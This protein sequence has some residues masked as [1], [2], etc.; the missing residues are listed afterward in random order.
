MM[1][2]F[3]ADQAEPHDLDKPIFDAA[4]LKQHGRRAASSSPPG[5][6]V[7]VAVISPPSSTITSSKERRCMCRSN[8]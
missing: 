7:R 6:M 1:S 8:R 5:G 4:H 2:V 3:V